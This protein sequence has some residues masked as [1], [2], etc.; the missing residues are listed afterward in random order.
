MKKVD[1]YREY[2][3]YQTGDED[4]E[5]TEAAGSRYIRNSVLVFLPKEV[6][7]KIGHEWNSCN[8]V[9]E[10]K[11]IIDAAAGKMPMHDQLINADKKSREQESEMQRQREANTEEIERRRRERQQEEYTRQRGQ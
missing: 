5:I 7:P 9:D 8:T 2:L 11:K 10:A 3:L 6:N 1:V 4:T